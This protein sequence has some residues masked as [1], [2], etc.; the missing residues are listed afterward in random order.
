MILDLFKKKKIPLDPAHREILEQALLQRSKMD[1]VFEENVT[2]I[3]GLSCSLNN[4]GQQAMALDIFGLSKPGNFTDR[5][6]SCYFRI[7]EGKS[8][9]GFHSFRA[10]VLEVRQTRHGGIAFVAA[11][12]EKVD[13]SQRRRSI[14]VRPDLNWFEECMFWKGA[15]LQNPENDAILLGLNELRQGK[16]CWL[17]NISAGGI[18]MHLEREFCRQSQFCPAV[19][20][21]FTVYLRFAQ[22]MR[23]QPRELWFTGKA[24]RVSEDAVSKDLDVGVEFRHVGRRPE[25]EGEMDWVSVQENVAEELITR[26]FEWHA[27]IWRERGGADE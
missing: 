16:L 27:A 15:K 4:I 21:E 24:V 17:K 1:F 18:G 11:L 25:A 14:R 13:R 2:T 12:P 5:Y 8:G 6:F 23:N 3:T 22:D 9:I 19:D 7:R 26:I 20:D 10:K